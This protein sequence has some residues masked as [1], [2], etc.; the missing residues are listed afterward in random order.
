[1]APACAPADC[2]SCVSRVVCHCL[3]VT[4]DNVIEAITTLALRT[5][6]DIQ[7]HT[8]AGDGC[9]ACHARLRAF[10]EQGGY[11]AS[12]PICSVK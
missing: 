9:T 3:N 5:V 1:M 6:K 12:S 10:L 2:Q 11:L 7:K 8:G 4:E